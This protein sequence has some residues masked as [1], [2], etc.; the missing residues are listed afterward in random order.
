M[1]SLGQNPTEDDLQV[2]IRD[3][4]A[5]E[6]TITLEKYLEIMANKMHDITPEAEIEE[7]FKV[8][9]KSG[10]GRIT[11]AELRTVMTNL[12]TFLHNTHSFFFL[13]RRGLQ[14]RVLVYRRLFCIGEKLAD[15]D[16]DNMIREADPDGLG[17]VDLE[18]AHPS[19]STVTFPK[20][21]F[22]HDY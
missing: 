14:Y 3:V 16:V 15:E 22:F 7:A 5:G 18:R 9:N 12:G 11:S 19:P 21:F 1:R 4:D 20:Y 13:F 10:T 6:G 8:F 2:M 17:Y